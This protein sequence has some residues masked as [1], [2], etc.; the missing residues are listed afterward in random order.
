MGKKVTIS[1]IIT[2]HAAERMRERLALDAKAS[3]KLALRAFVA[4]KKHTQCKGNLKKY[5]DEL[6]RQ[7]ETCNNIRVYGEVIFLFAGNNLVTVYHLPNELKAI[8]KK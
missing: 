6:Y 4:G 3:A 7:K 5:V 8:A 1:I 2:E